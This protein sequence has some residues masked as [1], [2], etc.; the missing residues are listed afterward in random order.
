MGHWKM[1]QGNKLQYLVKWAGYPD[2]DNTWEPVDQIHAP[3]LIKQYQKQHHLSI[4]ALRT[5]VKTRCAF[6]PEQSQPNQNSYPP[7]L[8]LSGSPLSSSNPTCNHDSSSYGSTI[9][10]WT[11]PWSTP[12]SAKTTLIPTIILTGPRKCQPSPSTL[13]SKHPLALR[14]PFG[15][16]RLLRDPSP[17]AL[18]NLW[19]SSTK[20]TPSLSSTLPRASPPP[21]GKESSRT[22]WPPWLSMTKYPTSNDGWTTIET[23]SR[24]RRAS[25]LRGTLLMTRPGYQTSLYRWGMGTISKRIGSNNWLKGKWQGSSGSMFWGKPHLLRKCTLPQPQGKKTLWDLSMPCQ[26]GSGCYSR[27]PLPT[28]ACCSNT[29]KLLTIGEWSEKSS[30]SD[31][32]STI[33]RTSASES[34]IMRPN[35]KEYCRLRPQ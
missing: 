1:R 13:W 27:D 2:S 16:L 17:P 29:L 7:K 30:N 4:K 28:T 21:S 15:P 10:L 24:F 19:W 35:L 14:P 33:Y 6:S 18:P 12:S 22:P 8:L 5:I 9:N 3:D 31:N 26:V 34:P 20:T 25:D 23:Q 32:S 11:M